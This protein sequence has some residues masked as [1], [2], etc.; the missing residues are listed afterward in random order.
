[1]PW[2]FSS[3]SSSANLEQVP[4]DAACEPLT[5]LPPKLHLRSSSVASHSSHAAL[6]LSHSPPLSPSLFS[7]SSPPRPASEIGGA[8]FAELLSRDPRQSVMMHEGAE[9]EQEG[10]EPRHQESMLVLE[11]GDFAVVG[12]DA[13]LLVEELHRS[14][15]SVAQ[16]KRRRTAYVAGVLSLVVLFVTLWFLVETCGSLIDEGGK[17]RGVYRW[18]ELSF[19]L[20]V[21][22]MWI[23]VFAF[24]RSRRISRLAVAGIICGAFSSF[25]HLSLAFTNF[26]LSFVWR[27]DLDTRCDWGVDVSFT[28][29]DKGDDCSPGDRVGGK[30]WSG[31]AAVRLVVTL[32][33]LATWLFFLRRYNLALH[34][35]L[36]ISPSALPS[37][38]LRS[39][40]ERHRADIFPLSSAAHAAHAHH[41][42]HTAGEGE[43][44][45]LPAMPERGA[46]YALVSEESQ[47]WSYRGTDEQGENGGGGG[48]GEGR[49]GGGGVG[50][51]MGAK[52]W[53]GVGW[54]FGVQPYEKAKTAAEDEEKAVGDVEKTASQR[55]LDEHQPRPPSLLSTS[56]PSYAASILAPQPD[57]RSEAYQ[58]L[59]DGLRRPP[60]IS[61]FSIS[62][63]SK[64][65]STGTASSSAA[66]LNRPLPTPDEEDEHPTEPDLSAPPPPAKVLSPSRP[67]LPHSSYSHGSSG[68]SRGAI[69]YVRMSDGRLVRRLSTIASVSEA[70]ASSSAGDLLNTPTMHRSRSTL[71]S[72]GGSESFATA[73]EAV[74]WHRE[75]GGDEEEVLI[76]D[77]GSGEVVEEW[78][79]RSE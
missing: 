60:S 22:P 4:T 34:T 64:R 17:G 24:L 52:L 72:S 36:R 10:G 19:F 45:H 48:E 70:G 44:D 40:L 27:D 61:S 55:D 25:L 35:P 65:F 21:L 1:M 5:P 74:Q 13:R 14:R 67:P 57:D 79:M 30:A 23:V 73:A 58:H 2:P 31:A 63:S 56:H 43:A 75:N 18:V 6:P 3:S 11:G 16:K 8:S 62:S 47:M 12:P 68:S 37:S 50:T 15:I 69:V 78:R 77:E 39:L 33:F 54:L 38:E 29:G 20:T 41:L 42:P 9:C 49:K 46:H 28:M 76:L 7:S 71:E 32:L 59:F 66:L 53:G 51:W 26:I